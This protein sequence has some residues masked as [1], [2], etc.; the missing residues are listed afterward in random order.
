[1]WMNLVVH[2]DSASSPI[3]KMFLYFTYWNSKKKFI[4]KKWFNMIN[5]H[6]LRISLS[7][8]GFHSKAE[9]ESADTCAGTAFLQKAARARIWKTLT[10][11]SHWDSVNL[12][13]CILFFSFLTLILE[14]MTI[15]ILINF[16]WLEKCHRDF[17]SAL[18]VKCLTR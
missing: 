8:Q 5:S 14:S 10:F 11:R 16:S 2:R 3:L 18:E 13:F 7:L 15:F 4:F 17:F 9:T 12:K 6:E 1:M